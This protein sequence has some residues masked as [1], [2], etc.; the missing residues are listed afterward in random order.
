MFSYIN[1]NAVSVDTIL[2]KLYH[3]ID[4][5]CLALLLISIIFGV[6]V[7]PQD[8]N[9]LKMEVNQPTVTTQVHRHE[10]GFLPKI[11]Y[12]IVS[13]YDWLSGPAMSEQ[14]RVHRELSGSEPW[15]RMGRMGL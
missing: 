5:N 15:R 13:I 11:A 10:K 8:M 3:I 7:A 6:A 12:Q 4:A 2:S 1:S 9:L 14:E